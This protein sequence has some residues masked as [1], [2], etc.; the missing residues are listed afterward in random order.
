MIGGEIYNL[1]KNKIYY[2]NRITKNNIKNSNTNILVKCID[3]N[4][5]NKIKLSIV[6][7]D[8]IYI[9]NTPNSSARTYASLIITLKLDIEKQ[10][11]LVN[12]FNEYLNNEREKYHSLFLTNYRETNVIA[13]KRISFKLA[14]DIVNHLLNS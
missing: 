14:F 1:T 10:T 3:D 9:D 7:N 6:N 2:I 12:K 11:I 13:R 4:S 8:N 5:K